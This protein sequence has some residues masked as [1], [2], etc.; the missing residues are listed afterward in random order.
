MKKEIDPR[1]VAL[2]KENERLMKSINRIKL[3]AESIKDTLKREYK[4]EI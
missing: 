2:E 4:C 1:I 3:V